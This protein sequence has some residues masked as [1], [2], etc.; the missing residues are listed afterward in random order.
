MTSSQAC[1]PRDEIF[2][3]VPCHLSSVLCLALTYTGK[4]VQGLIGNE[5][6]DVSSLISNVDNAVMNSNYSR[7]IVY[8]EIYSSMSGHDTYTKRHLINEFTRTAFTRFRFSR[9]TLTVETGRWNRQLCGS[10]PFE[11]RVCVCDG[12][13]LTERHVVEYCP[14]PQQ[15]R[16]NY[17]VVKQEHLFEANIP[18]G[19]TCKIFNE[20]LEMCG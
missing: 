18:H 2:R 6:T 9:H 1:G 14:L 4:L 17:G 15:I 3:M 12:G 20:I 8:R 7:C 16:E 19:T 10:L 5:L 13:V 11:E